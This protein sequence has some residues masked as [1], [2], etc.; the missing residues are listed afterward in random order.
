MTNPCSA[1]RCA[2]R[3]AG[4]FP[5]AEIAEVGTFDDLHALLEQD[6]EFDLI[7]LDLT[8]PGAARVFRPIY[9]RAQYAGVPVVVVSGYEEAAVI[10]RC[11][12]LGAS[13]F[14]PKT[15][16]IAANAPGRGRSSGGG[17]AVPPDLGPGTAQDGGDRRHHLPLATLTPS[18][19]AC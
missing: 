7:L 8:M 11:L 14:I 10:R 3:L 2:K 13:G 18:K 16:G 12:D 4:Q 5:S 19:C 1:V 9:L 15:M 6:G 17:T